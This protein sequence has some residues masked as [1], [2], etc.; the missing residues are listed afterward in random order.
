MSVNI[1]SNCYKKFIS[2]SHLKR[3]NNSKNGCKRPEV[4]IITSEYKYDDSE[5]FM[6]AFRNIIKDTNLMT[7][8]NIKLALAL[9]EDECQS[10]LEQDLIHKKIF[11]CFDC[12]EEFAFRQGLHRHQK[13]NRCRA[14]KQGFSLD[15]ILQ[16]TPSVEHI[17]INNPNVNIY[18]NENSNIT[19][20][21][22]IKNYITNNYNINFNIQPF[23][24]ESLEHITL[25]DFK[26]IFADSSKLMNKLCNYV[27]LQNLSNISF[28]KHNLNKQIISFLSKNM[29]IEKIDEKGFI[30]QFTRL[31]EDTC[32]LLFYQHKEQLTEQELIKYMKR[33]VEYQ[34]TILYEKNGI[35]Q[36]DTKNCILNLMDTA[37][38]NKDI[39]Y[40]IEKIIKDLNENLLAKNDIVDRLTDDNYKRDNIINEFYDKQ[41][42]TSHKIE[43]EAQPNTNKSLHKIRKKAIEQNKDDTKA[44]RKRAIE[45]SLK[46]VKFS[47]NDDD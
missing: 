32:I 5:S 17:E 42:S 44:S 34:D 47:T 28:Y 19:V 2:P 14:K 11:K 7:I 16:A 33:L 38:R 25:K 23:G 20:D 18:D 3:H 41:T 27:F 40:N 4:E 31:L 37:F 15:D 10:R 26:Y 13:D 24:L 21:A 36:T 9:L 22:S 6:T 43:K 29:E 8:D 46:D 45:N 39:K 30:M 12:N 35:I 1:C